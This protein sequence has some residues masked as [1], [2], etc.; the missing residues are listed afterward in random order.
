MPFFAAKSGHKLVSAIGKTGIKKSAI[1][2]E[3]NRIMVFPPFNM[4]DEL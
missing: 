2:K 4:K 3:K 1:K